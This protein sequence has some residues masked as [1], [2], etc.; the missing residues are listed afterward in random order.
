MV[1]LPKGR[2]SDIY[3]KQWVSSNA[4]AG[5]PEHLGCVPREL[6]QTKHNRKQPKM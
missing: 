4:G 2:D 1:Q 5:V 6:N 3:I